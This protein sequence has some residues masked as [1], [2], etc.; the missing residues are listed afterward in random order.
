M[1]WELHASALNGIM[2]IS[3]SNRQKVLQT[4]RTLLESGQVFIAESNGK[5]A[6]FVS[7]EK[8]SRSL[9]VEKNEI[10]IACLYLNP[11][12]RGSGIG[13]ALMQKCIEELK[14][15]GFERITLNVTS[16][17]E[18][19]KALYGKLG[20]KTKRETMFLDF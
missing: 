12:F 5:I 15:K 3:E 4:L 17:N 18:R 1:A 10:N 7:Y 19:A 8:K 9:E 13:K 11:E 6:G 16:S 14:S 2:K 20:F